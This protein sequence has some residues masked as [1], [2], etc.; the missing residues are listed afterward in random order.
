MALPIGNVQGLDSFHPNMIS[1]HWT[2]VL[3]TNVLLLGLFFADHLGVCEQHDLGICARSAH[4]VR[5][6]PGHVNIA[7]TRSGKVG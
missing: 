7:N 6:L 2:C 5:V 3:F 1:L 4:S